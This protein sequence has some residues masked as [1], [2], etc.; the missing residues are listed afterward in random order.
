MTRIA[1][2]LAACILALSATSAEAQ[3]RQGQPAVLPPPPPAADPSVAILSQFR[4]AYSAAGSPRIVIFWNREFDDEVASEY[5]DRYSEH[6]VESTS[7]NSLEE[8][9]SGPAGV[10]VRGES[11]DLR[12]RRLE[13]VAGTKRVRPE[14]RGHVGSEAVDWQLEQAFAGTMQ[15][16]GAAIVD[17][18]MALRLAGVALGAGERANVQELETAGMSEFA[19][20]I[21]EVLQSPDSRS[22]NG[23]TFRV[24]VRDLRNARTVASFVSAG[25]P[26]ARRM[27]YVAGPSGFV[28]ATAPEPGPSQIGGQLALETMGNLARSLR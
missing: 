24:L 28:R 18:T 5:E 8:T 11:G 16:G 15:Q 23:V 9:T 4:S 6:E 13:T 25:Q 1:L 20:L 22:P 19:D 26:P 21:V 7:R 2:T 14:A 17:R 12:E 3:R 27:P 10:A